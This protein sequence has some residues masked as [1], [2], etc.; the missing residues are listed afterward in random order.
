VHIYIYTA[1]KGFW[2]G[3]SEEADGNSTRKRLQMLRNASVARIEE[4]YIESKVPE[5]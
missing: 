2:F 1:L 4:R 5:A 3:I